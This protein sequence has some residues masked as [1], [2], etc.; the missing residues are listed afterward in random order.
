[1]EKYYLW[2]QKH[3]LTTLTV[4]YVFF[5]FYSTVVPFNFV[6]DLKAVIPRLSKI[7]WI[8]F[9][10]I[11]RTFS[12]SDAIANILFFMPLG[13]LLAAKRI[14]HYYRNFSFFDWFLIVSVGFLCSMSVEFFQIFTL[15]RHTS[16]TDLM[17]NTLGT[18][19][20]A[21]I[22]LIIYLRFRVV[23]KKILYNIFFGK[24][25][26]IIA[27]LFLIV[28]LIGSAIPF[29]FQPSLVSIKEQF[30][31]LRMS[32]ISWKSILISLPSQIML[33]GSFTYFFLVG[34]LKYY[35]KK[36]SIFHLTLFTF[37]LMIIPVALEIFQ[38]LIPIRNHSV[39]DI[40]TSSGGV[41]IGAAVFLLQQSQSWI[42]EKNVLPD[43]N[44]Q[45]FAHFY[46]YQLFTL[47]YIL[48][49]FIIFKYQQPLFSSAEIYGD[50][51]KSVTKPE[52]QLMKIKRLNFL[53][54]FAKEVF[55]F[56]PAGFII[57]LFLR[58][59]KKVK[60]TLFAI[61]ALL[62]HLLYFLYVLSQNVNSN[63]FM[64]IGL[65]TLSIGMISGYVLYESYAYLM[66][67]YET[68]HSE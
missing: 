43:R 46:F 20:G 52:Y 23:I 24:P 14:L 64:A 65:L 51:F 34:S 9:G 8:P 18:I 7:D 59:F 60:N 4:L 6:P 28:I 31:T 17:M 61:I 58:K 19:I 21:G 41:L 29:T 42:V 35:Y 54:Q 63:F 55:T 57:S 33:F 68:S 66:D 56:L 32:S 47:T 45:L 40:L 11:H 49:L 1:M 30:N 53:I 62:L 67:K 16:M 13:L 5:I 22:M 27:G 36:F 25:E 2:F 38:T 10:G 44:G 12:R 15:D 37:L 50:L 39:S 26:A 48:Y 3:W